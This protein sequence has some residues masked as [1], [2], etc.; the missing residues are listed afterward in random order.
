MRAVDGARYLFPGETTSV[1]FLNDETLLVQVRSPAELHVLHYE[2]D[3]S[4]RLTKVVLSLREVRG[5]G[6]QVFH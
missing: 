4:T 6:H 3:G 5:T 1:Q 2:T